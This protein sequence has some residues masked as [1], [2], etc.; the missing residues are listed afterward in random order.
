MSHT[1][2]SNASLAEKKDALK[3]ALDE[4]TDPIRLRQGAIDL[5]SHGLCTESWWQNRSLPRL[6]T[7]S[8]NCNEV[9]YN[10]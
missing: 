1:L 5:R 9:I 6:Y 8:V 2:H 3:K 10:M 4:R 7:I